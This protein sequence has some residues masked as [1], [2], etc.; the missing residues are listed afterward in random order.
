[1]VVN[2]LVGIGDIPQVYQLLRAR[3]LLGP[4]GGGM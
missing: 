2:A 1:M 3:Q 4:F